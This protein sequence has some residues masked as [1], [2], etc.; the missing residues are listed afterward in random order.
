M[1][2]FRVKSVKIYT[3]QKGGQP[4]N[5]TFPLTCSF[6]RLGVSDGASPSLSGSIGEIQNNPLLMLLLSHDDDGG[7]LHNNP[8]I[9]LLLSDL[10]QH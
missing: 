3:G 2:I 7:E 5:S 1:L 4:S 9:I 6:C 10:R 8:F